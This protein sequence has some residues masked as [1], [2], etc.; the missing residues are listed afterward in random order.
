MN[1]VL[2]Y[3]ETSAKRFP[4]KT[5]LA[6]LEEEVSFSQL[7]ETAKRIGT[8]LAGKIHRC[9]PVPVLL[10]KC[11]KAVEV[12]LGAVYAGCFYTML[13][14][15][16]P[17]ER[18][19]R[20]LQT[21]NAKVLV[22]DKEGLELAKT[23][24]E[25][26]NGERDAGSLPEKEAAVREKPEILL[27]ED[28]AG[29]AQDSVLLQSIRGKMVDTDPL[30]VNFTSGST[31]IPKGVAVCHRSVIDFIDCFT[32]IFGITQEDV[33]G[34]QAPFDFDVSVKDLYSTL[35][36]GASMQIIPQKYFS[37][38]TQLMDFL[39][40]RNVTTLIWAVSALTLLSRMHVFDYR[41]PGKI[42]KVIFSGEV[43]PVRHLNVWREALPEAEFYNV[44]GPTE[45]TCNCTWYQVQ[46]WFDPD[47]PA[48]VIP[49]G[50]PFPNERVFLLDEE[51]HLVTE[52]GIAG[53]ICVAGTALALGYYR[54]PE[55]TAAAFVQNPLNDRY[56]EQIYRT[57]DLAVYSEDGDLL[58]IGRKD[59]QIKHMGH[60]IELGEIEKAMQAILGTEQCCCLFLKEKITAFYTGDMDKKELAVRLRK[61][62]PDYMIP[63]RFLRKDALPLS[64]NGKIDRQQLAQGC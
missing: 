16:Q 55:A 59:F 19:A 12:F 37:I 51:D 11:V 43:M 14:Q 64:K 17:K 15:R 44:Y 2:A 26:E 61:Y 48:D 13:D 25:E 56:P 54:N 50:K 40:D 9:C 39:L 34:N 1:N 53:E 31:G 23:L 18:L 60:R 21:L 62:L 10:P 7:E 30:Y 22:T 20:I 32:E 4:D 58:Y 63:N 41:I 27:F 6:D 33:I 3:L 57:G 46:R 47:D 8:A 38:P 35:K 52:P 24:L 29:G 36:T 45:I 28:L 42:R 5:A 49:I